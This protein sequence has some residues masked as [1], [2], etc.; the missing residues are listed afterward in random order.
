MSVWHAK[1]A[2]QTLEQLETDKVRGLSG[3]EAERRLGRYGPNRLQ[4][5]KRESL[6]RRFFGQMKDPMI[7]V[8]LAA[9][10]LS[11]W[12]SGGEDWLD[13]VIILVIVVVNACISISQ[14]DSAERALE[15][16][17]RMSAPLARVVRDGRLERVEAA[18]LVPGDI[19][20][21]EAGDLVPADTRILESAGLTA[22]ESAMTGES[23][24]VSKGALGALPEDTPLAD[25]KNMLLSATVITAGRAAGVVVGTGMDTEVGRI[26]GLMLGEESAQTPLQK[27]MA[28]ISR[29]LSFLCLCVCA[30]M[31]GVG[32]LQGKDLLGM[33]LTAVSLAVAA[34]PEGLPA[35]VT[36]VLALG[37]Q[38]MV[39]RG[40]IV[41]R[42]PAVETLGCASVICSDKTGTLTQNKMNV[43]DVWTPRRGER[44]LALTIG[45][46][47]SDA[48][49]SYRGRLP[50]CTGDPTETA[51]VELAEREGVEKNQL[52]A[53]WPRR[54]ELPFDSTRKLMTT[55]HQKPGGGFRV[56]VKGAPDVLLRR[57]RQAGTGRAAG[58]NE[59]MAAKALRVLGV[60]YKD[61][62]FL[63]RELSSA[64]LE[65]DLTFVG[66]LGLMDPPRPEAREAV[67]Q[68]FAA[69]IR[70]VMITGDHKLTAVAVAREL[71]IFRAGDLAITGEDLDFM[72]QE[73]LEEE[74]EKFSVYARVSPE[75]KMRIV[76]AWQARGKV[77][78]MTGDGVNDAPALK[79]ADIGC[80]MGITGTDVAK[81]AA[82]MILTDDNFA[83][84][85]SAVEQGRGIYA[86][87]KK[88]IHYLLSCNIGEILTIFL[89]TL[90][91]FH[92]MPLVP[93]QLLWLNLVTDSLPAL[94]LG[95]EPVEEGVMDQPP[96]EAHASLFAHGFALRLAWQGV[97]VGVLTLAAYFLGEYVLSDPGQASSTA[98]TMAFATLTLCQLFHAFDVRSERASL[99]HIGLLSNRA[100]NRAFLVG[101]AMQLAVLCIPPLQA[102]FNT[103]P[104]SP[105]EW[106][107]VL[108]LAVTPVV[109][110]EA[111]KA[112]GRGRVRRK[113]AGQAGKEALLSR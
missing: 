76:K 88:A 17:R 36:I 97:M 33:F 3:E 15:A 63:P 19:I 46:L 38:R 30:V 100:M 50:Q 41:K 89:A 98:N 67:E 99:L 91:D 105:M 14:E 42:L 29:T 102:I 84:I 23:V 95:V 28:E 60:A 18:D 66:L 61:L 35:I 108:A 10:A 51:I 34:I 101:M 96:R 53:D 2:R 48:V 79:V 21:L 70:P 64:L 109:V 71:G 32:L 65:Q 113:P 25:R 107:V 4:G 8:L 5:T 43:V 59:A 94:A 86:N 12:A 9:A 104:M 103:V 68:C 37:V 85:V 82:D 92:Q 58:R 52:E 73:L 112:A 81:G 56:C 6:P 26:A 54:G 90:F 39:K 1:S 83:T 110:C 20:R 111:V 44:A 93:V 80:A 77:T 7:L 49:L 16:L 74:V 40:A 62:E 75:H 87:I 24:P 55:V 13:A 57:C 78:A 72:P 69:G 106:A 45:T 11:L 22:D 27:K 47:C 31:F